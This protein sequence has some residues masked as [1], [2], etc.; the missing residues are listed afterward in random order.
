MKYCSKCGKKSNALTRSGVCQD[1]IL[2]SRR[3]NKFF[4]L[5]E[6]VKPSEPKKRGGFI[7][8]KI[9][10]QNKIL[11]K[12]EIKYK[13]NTMN[14]MKKTLLPIAIIISTC[15]Y[16]WGN[17]YYLMST[18]AQTVY[19]TVKHDKLTGDTFLLRQG[20]NGAKPYWELINEYDYN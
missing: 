13:T 19:G 7:V 8:T 4:K 15:I 16:V 6:N 1:C 17:R 5:F 2:E 20:K 12:E 14:F 11:N 3:D 10:P 18:S 9:S